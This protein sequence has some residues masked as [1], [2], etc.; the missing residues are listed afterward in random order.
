MPD[1]TCLWPLGNMSLPTPPAY[2]G[3]PS[4]GTVTCCA[5]GDYCLENGICKITN[6][7]IKGSSGYYTAGCSDGTIEMDSNICPSRCG[8]LNHL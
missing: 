6:Y 5:K 3:D 4:G 8:Q 1:V 7:D 2:C